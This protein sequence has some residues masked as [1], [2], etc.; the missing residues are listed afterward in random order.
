MILR[1]ISPVQSASVHSRSSPSCL[2]P[3]ALVWTSRAV[4]SDTRARKRTRTGRRDRDPDPVGVGR[5][6]RMG[7]EFAEKSSE[8]AVGHGEVVERG[9]CCHIE[10]ERGSKSQRGEMRTSQSDGVGDPPLCGRPA[11]DCDCRCDA[12]Q[13]SGA[14]RTETPRHLLGQAMKRGWRG[15]GFAW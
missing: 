8:G 13:S 12:S 2:S 5:R 7:E 9:V 14:V 6:R 10:H 11:T 1:G 3:C 4:A 15:V